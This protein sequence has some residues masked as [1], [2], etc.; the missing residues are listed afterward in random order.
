[1]ISIISK[2]SCGNDRFTKLLLHGDGAQG[3]TIFTDSCQIANY[4]YPIGSAI[5]DQ[6]QHKFGSASI[7]LDG[8]N[9]HLMMPNDLDLN[10]SWNDFSIDF[11]VM[12]Y[13]LSKPLIYLMSTMD[14]TNTN[15]F[16][17]LINNGA[18]EFINSGSG[19]TVVDFMTP[20]FP[21][22]E[23]VWCHIALTRSNPNHTINTSTYRFFVNGLMQSSLVTSASNLAPS[24][25]QLVIGTDYLMSTF[26]AMWLDEVRICKGIA[27]W[28]KSFSVPTRAY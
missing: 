4:L 26:V 13:D 9:S 17:L 5:I 19:V 6:T 14:A 1:M 27:R 24:A 23:E 16:T 10:F 7:Y 25:S 18:L 2:A 15:G 28:Q 22:V 8:I 12:F 3:S 11:W 21:F 20:A